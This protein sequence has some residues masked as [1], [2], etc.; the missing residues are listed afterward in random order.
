MDLGS[1]G[2]T[3]LGWLI[4]LILLCGFSIFIVVKA[5]EHLS[6]FAIL[7]MALAMCWAA[8]LF[9]MM[10]RLHGVLGGL[11]TREEVANDRK[12]PLITSLGVATGLTNAALYFG[13]L[14]IFALLM[15]IILI[16]P[17]H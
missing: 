8:F 6:I 9:V 13:F 3:R 7:W 1:Y 15:A 16:L 11:C 4:T 14:S 10:L 17:R 2:V 12:S 5:R